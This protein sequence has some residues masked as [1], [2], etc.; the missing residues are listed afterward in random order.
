MDGTD[1]QHGHSSAHPRAREAAMEE[2]EEMGDDVRAAEMKILLWRKAFLN[3]TKAFY[4][5]ETTK[6]TSAFYDR[7]T[8]KETSKKTRRAWWDAP[9][10][11]LEREGESRRD[12]T[13]T[14]QLES[15][16]EKRQRGLQKCKC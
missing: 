15:A 2:M 3:T 11:P 9:R 7:E 1:V 8:M 10:E 13:Q 16:A 4:D 5:R 14:I 6:E 12:G